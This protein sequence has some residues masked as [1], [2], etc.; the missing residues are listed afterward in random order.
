MKRHR[1]SGMVGGIGTIR[2]D[3]ESDRSLGKNSRGGKGDREKGA[4]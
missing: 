4:A 1:V 3:F 2:G